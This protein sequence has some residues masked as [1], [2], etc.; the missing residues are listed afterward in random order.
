[1]NGFTLL[2]LATERGDVEIIQFLLENGADVNAS[3]LWLDRPLH[4]AVGTQFSAVKMLIE[5]G[6]DLNVWD[7]QEKLPLHYALSR[8]DPHIIKELVKKGGCIDSFLQ[9]EGSPSFL[10]LSILEERTYSLKNSLSQEKEV[11]PQKLHQKKQQIKRLQKDIHHLKARFHRKEKGVFI[12]SLKWK[13]LFN[14]LHY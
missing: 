6:A 10:L 11:S 4:F 3:T 12:P 8:E 14:Y 5:K 2:H 13:D 9:K 7:H 1:M